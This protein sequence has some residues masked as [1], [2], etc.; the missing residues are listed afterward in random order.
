MPSAA[1]STPLLS[2]YML[3]DPKYIPVWTAILEQAPGGNMLDCMKW[4]RSTML[5]VERKDYNDIHKMQIK[6]SLN[7]CRTTWL[8]RLPAPSR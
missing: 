4:E 2:P 3:L 7:L 5:S 6:M 1:A 8:V